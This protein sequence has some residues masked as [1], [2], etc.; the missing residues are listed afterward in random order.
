MPLW[1]DHNRS[2]L[3]DVVESK[4]RGNVYVLLLAK[5]IIN[6]LL[7]LALGTNDTDSPD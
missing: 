2:Y 3:Y 1:F 4:K 6:V 5:I 7:Q